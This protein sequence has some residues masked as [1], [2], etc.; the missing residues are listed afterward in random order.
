MYLCSVNGCSFGR[1]EL[2]MILDNINKRETS[3]PNTPQNQ[4]ITT[5]RPYDLLGYKKKKT[6][7]P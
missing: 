2:L 3:G 5:F 7:Q 6:I 1:S 4:G